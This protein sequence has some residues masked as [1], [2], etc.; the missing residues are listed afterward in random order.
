MAAPGVRAG[1]VRGSFGIR[2]GSVGA[3]FEVRLGPFGSI[4]GPFGVCLGSVR[5]PFGIRAGSVWGPP[6]VRSGSARDPFGIRAGSVQDLFVLCPGS[7]RDPFGVRSG[8]VRAPFG[9]KFSEPKI[10]NILNLCGRRRRGGAP[11]SS[12]CPNPD[13]RKRV[14]SAT[15]NKL[16]LTTTGG[17]KSFSKKKTD[18]VY[19]AENFLNFC[20]SIRPIPSLFGNFS[21]LFGDPPNVFGC[22]SSLFGCDSSLFGCDSSLFGGRV[23]SAKK[24][25]HPSDFGEPIRRG[26]KKNVKR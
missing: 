12:R 5:G 2:S 22:D 7:V 21:S 11:L 19:S 4:W 1:S 8:S 13:L 3:R 14:Y 17:R 24:S 20:E 25:M 10:S 16:F 6:E 15:L 26:A 9:P 23:Y 18:R